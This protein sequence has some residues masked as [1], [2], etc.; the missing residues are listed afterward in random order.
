MSYTC[1][2]TIHYQ[3][4]VDEDGNPTAAQIPWDEFEALLEEIEDSDEA[5]PEEA[6]AIDEANNDRAEGNDEAFTDLTDFMAEF[7][8]GNP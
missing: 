6:E 2:M 5:T 3:T 4:V 7:K 1:D 8:E